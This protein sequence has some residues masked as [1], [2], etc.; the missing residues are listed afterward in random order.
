PFLRDAI[1]KVYTVV[2]PN[3][4]SATLLPIIR[5][6]VKPDG[7]VYTDTFRSY[8]VLDVSEFSHL[9]KFNGIPKE[10]LGLY[11]KKCQWHLK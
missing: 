8:D 4:Q 9:R 10:H 6:K 1:Y 7:I 5:K 3:A 2:V 11:L